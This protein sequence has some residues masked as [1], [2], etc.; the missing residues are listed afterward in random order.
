MKIDI[1]TEKY[2]KAGRLIFDDPQIDINES[3]D[4]LIEDL[5]AVK[6]HYPEFDQDTFDSLLQLDPT[7]DPDKD[8]LGTYGKWILALAKKGVIKSTDE[9][10][11]ELLYDFN[12][13]KTWFTNKDIFQFKTPLQLATAIKEVKPPVLSNTQKR[14][15]AQKARKHADLN[16]EASL[17]Y[18]D[19]TWEVWIP[20]T[21]AASCKLGQNTTWCTATTENDRYYRSYTEEGPLYVIINKND[22]EEKY[23]F[24]F[25][26]SQ[27]MDKDDVGIDVAEFLDQNKGLKTFLSTKFLKKYYD[28]LRQPVPEAST[29]I[30]YKMMR[31]DLIDLFKEYKPDFYYN[32]GEALSGDFIAS[33]LSD[34][35]NVYDV[36]YIEDLT[37]I[38][39]IYF[40]KDAFKYPEV[41][42]RLQELDIS[43]E[44]Y[45]NF[46]DDEDSIDSDKAELLNASI[47]R[48]Y[49]DSVYIDSTDA[50][51]TDIKQ[52]LLNNDSLFNIDIIG[53][54]FESDPIITF[55]SESFAAFIL[56][57]E[58]DI[59]YLAETAG[60]NS[61]EA[62]LLYNLNDKLKIYEPRYGW[63]VYSEKTFWSCFEQALEEY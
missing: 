26:S 20:N 21:Y 51:Y 49:T 52:D 7:F 59:S 27:Y 23:Q 4:W 60:L 24:H 35:Y 44:E 6:V 32:R 58:Q 39:Q 55:N 33:V 22:P 47:N 10:I 34:I 8:T 16:N 19:S 36:G 29:K 13:K 46:I 43:E 42:K 5:T 1:E 54:E 14:K 56:S 38:N 2:I 9:D 48:A 41:S 50:M 17:V 40:I 25:E 15:Q 63:A 11:Y 61:F 18:E 31:S 30:S 45:L 62:A 37:A 3:I 53:F 28:V 57:A 12:K